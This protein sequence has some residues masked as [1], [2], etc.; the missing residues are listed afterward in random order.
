MDKKLKAET[1]SLVLLLIAFPVISTGAT[2]DHRAVWWI[3]LAAFVL[4]GLLPVWTRYMDHSTDKPT[5]MGM[6]YDERT[7]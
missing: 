3:G 5:D 4:G 6:E 1:V 2:D 7:S